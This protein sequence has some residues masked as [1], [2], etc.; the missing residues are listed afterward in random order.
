MEPITIDTRGLTDQAK[1]FSELQVALLEV[2]APYQGADLNEDLAKEIANAID[3]SVRKSGL[4]PSIAI[5][6]T[7]I[8]LYIEHPRGKDFFHANI[9]LKLK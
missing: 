9:N 1:L 4:I 7:E 5:Y 2:M 3:K 8:D 6:E